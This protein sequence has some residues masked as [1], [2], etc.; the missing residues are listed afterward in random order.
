MLRRSLKWL[1]FVIQPGEVKVTPSPFFSPIYLVM[2][3]QK[4]NPH[5]SAVYSIVQAQPPQIHLKP[6][7]RKI[8]KIPWVV[9]IYTLNKLFYFDSHSNLN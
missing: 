8:C 6:W 3:F 5:I 2:T 9:Q 4:G 7:S 1:G